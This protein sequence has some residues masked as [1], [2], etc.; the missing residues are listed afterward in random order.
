MCSFHTNLCNSY[1]KVKGDKKVIKEK[2]LSVLPKPLINL[3][4]LLILN[5]KKIT[6]FTEKD[7]DFKTWRVRSVKTCLPENRLPDH[8]AG[9]I[10]FRNEVY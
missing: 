3:S 5:A 6:D 8:A 10:V 1:L 7:T 9:I 4:Y 2:Q